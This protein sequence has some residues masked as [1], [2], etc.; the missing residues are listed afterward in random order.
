MATGFESLAEVTWTE[1]ERRCAVVMILIRKGEIL[2]DSKIAD[3]TG[4]DS[5][6]VNQLK[7][8][9]DRDQGPQASCFP[10]TKSLDGLQE[11]QEGPFTSL[12]L[13]SGSTGTSIWRSWRAPSFPGSRHWQEIVFGCG[14]KTRSPAMSPTDPSS[15]S[16]ITGLEGLLASQ[17]S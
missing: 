16:R 4:V 13:A 7:R 8:G 15:G 12:R 9:S 2:T 17:R 14:H 5:R 3:L 11:G 10:C 1:A 6:R